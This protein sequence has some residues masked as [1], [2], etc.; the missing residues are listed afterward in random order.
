MDAWLR[1]LYE[2]IVLQPMDCLKVS[3]PSFVYVIQNNLLYIAVSN[4]EAAT[5]QVGLITC[6]SLSSV[7]VCVC[8]CVCAC[9][10]VCACPLVFRYHHVLIVYM[11]MV[12]TLCVCVCS[13]IVLDITS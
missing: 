8:V 3:V 7:C 2:N 1:H 5:F 9:V 10:H 11:C 6:V 13:F 4:L 12:C